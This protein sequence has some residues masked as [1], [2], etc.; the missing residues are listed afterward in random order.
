MPVTNTDNEEARLARLA[1]DRQ[2]KAGESNA[3]QAIC[4]PRQLL[5]PTSKAGRQILQSGTKV[6]RQLGKKEFIW[7]GQSLQFGSKA[8]G[9]SVWPSSQ[10]MQ[11]GSKVVRQSGRKAAKQSNSYAVM[12]SDSQAGRH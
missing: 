11:L 6:V 5:Q 2:S 7:S 4:E 1:Q 12:Q 10:C 3:V 8:L 9:H